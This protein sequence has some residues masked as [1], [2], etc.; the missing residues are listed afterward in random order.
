MTSPETD[1]IVRFEETGSFY[2]KS[3]ATQQLL[4][5][6][7]KLLAIN[8]FARCLIHYRESIKGNELDIIGCWQLCN[9]FSDAQVGRTLRMIWL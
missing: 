5:L 8:M 1:E 6:K 3:K 2:Q 9:S 7:K 4:L